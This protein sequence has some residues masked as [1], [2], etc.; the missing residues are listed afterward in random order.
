M[1][2]G[3][4]IIEKKEINKEKKKLTEGPFFWGNSYPESQFFNLTLAIYN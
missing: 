1:D 2:S 3:K 4:K